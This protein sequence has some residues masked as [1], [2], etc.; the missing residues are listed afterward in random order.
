MSALMAFSVLITMHATIPVHASEGNILISVTTTPRPIADPF[1]DVTFSVSGLS[2]DASGTVLTFEGISYGYNNLPQMW[3]LY[4]D[5]LYDFEWASTVSGGSGKQYVWTSTSGLST[6]RSGS[7]AVQSGGSVSAT[8]KTQYYLSVNSPYV[9]D[10]TGWYDAGRTVTLSAPSSQGFL[11]RQI[12]EEWTGDIQSTSEEVSITMDGPKN[13]N[14]V[15]TTDYSQL[16][17]ATILTLASTG[18]LIGNHRR[19]TKIRL[20]KGNILQQLNEVAGTL[21]LSEL[22]EKNKVSEDKVRHLIDEAV[23]KGNVRGIYTKDGKG[24]VTEKALRQIVEDRL[25]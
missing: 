8:Y 15:W 18:I 20:L 21:S 23:K 13:V 6:S 12:F 25:K 19:T 1:Y 11:V 4:H 24:F 17:M 14:V 9:I 16:Y 22:A 7:I 2:G 5:Y 10:S 3:G